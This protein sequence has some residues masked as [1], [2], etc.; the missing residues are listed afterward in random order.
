MNPYIRKNH[1]VGREVIVKKNI[2]KVDTS[3]K[4]T[5]DRER[6]KRLLVTTQVCKSQKIDL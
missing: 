6:L 1:W 3:I 5:F 4:L 2:W